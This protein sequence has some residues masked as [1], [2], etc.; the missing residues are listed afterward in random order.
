MRGR[1]E[2]GI[3]ERGGG[4][5]K[6]REGRVG[7]GGQGVKTGVREAKGLCRSGG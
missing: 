1:G 4:V 2:G 5:I 3:R 7:G 6:G